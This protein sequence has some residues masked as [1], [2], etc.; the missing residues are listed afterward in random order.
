MRVVHS[1]SSLGLKWK[2][3]NIWEITGQAPGKCNF[4]KLMITKTEIYKARTRRT[5]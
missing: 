4:I 2:G 1:S 5:K 3:K